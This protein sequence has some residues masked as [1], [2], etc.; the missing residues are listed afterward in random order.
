MDQRHIEAWFEEKNR[1][2]VVD[3]DLPDYDKPVK[4]SSQFKSGG[5]Q[6]KMFRDKTSDLNK[7]QKDSKLATVPESNSRTPSII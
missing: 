2:D 6:L 4:K 7:H 5:S 3:D 1:P